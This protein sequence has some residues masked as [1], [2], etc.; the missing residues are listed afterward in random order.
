MS[1]L[2]L[3]TQ[4]SLFLRILSSHNTNFFMCGETL[5][6][7]SW[8]FSRIYIIVRYDGTRQIQVLDGHRQEDFWV[9]GQSQSGLEWISEQLGLYSEI[10]SQNKT[11][12]KEYTLLLIIFS[13]LHNN[14]LNILLSKNLDPCWISSPALWVTKTGGSLT[15]SSR[16]SERSVSEE[17]SGEWRAGCHPLASM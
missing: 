15:L 13:E 1:Y 9:Q 12:Q 7:Y 16:F 6:T 2:E 4:W 14:L 17:S 11:K 10:L 3:S 8:E 5:K